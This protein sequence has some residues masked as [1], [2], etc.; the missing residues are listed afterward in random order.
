MSSPTNAAK[1]EVPAI[2]SNAAMD[3]KVLSGLEGDI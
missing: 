1:N 2:Q 3:T